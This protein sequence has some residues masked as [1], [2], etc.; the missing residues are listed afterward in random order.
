[1]ANPIHRKPKKSEIVQL[2]CSE[3]IKKYLQETT[4]HGLKYLADNTLTLWEK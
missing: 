3:N 2:Y 1:M 4:L